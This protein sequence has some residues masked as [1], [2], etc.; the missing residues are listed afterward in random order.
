MTYV[1]DIKAFVAERVAVLLR[2]DLG[3]FRQF[4]AKHNPGDP[5]S[6]SSDD[7]VE[8]ALHKARTASLGL[9][10]EVRSASKA[11]LKSRGYK[12]WDDKP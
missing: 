6:M 11:W 8:I 1:N 7:V 2:G 3:E 10:E 4:L 5:F 12:H 9:P